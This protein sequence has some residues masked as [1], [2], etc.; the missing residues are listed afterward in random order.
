MSAL[1][2]ACWWVPFPRE[3]LVFPARLELLT[4]LFALSVLAA[5][6]LYQPRA[7]IRAERGTGAAP[8][9]GVLLPMGLNLVQLL[10]VG[11]GFGCGS[12]PTVLEE[13]AM[14]RDGSVGVQGWAHLFSPLVTWELAS[15]GGVGGEALCPGAGTAVL[16]LSGLNRSQR[17]C[18]VL[19]LRIN[20][21]QHPAQL[22][23][24]AF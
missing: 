17:H 11:L 24:A 15:A 8:G 20:I 21:P 14:S 9:T 23:L 2:I 16:E 12:Q 18:P 22:S 1:L 7:F 10:G 5:I 13:C 3:S 19:H 6:P 4:V